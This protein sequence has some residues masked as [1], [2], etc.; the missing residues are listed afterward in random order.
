M[1]LLLAAPN[2]LVITALKNV[3]DWESISGGEQCRQRVGQRQ[4][5]P[6]QPGHTMENWEGWVLGALLT[7]TF[8]EFSPHHCCSIRSVWNT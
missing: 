1:F 7:P 8:I 2:M 3:L 6:V 5:R 4:Q